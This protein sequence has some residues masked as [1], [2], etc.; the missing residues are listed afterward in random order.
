MKR[1][2]IVVLAITVIAAAALFAMNLY[3][4]RDPGQASR[5]EE[6]AVPLERPGL[7]NLHRVTEDFYRGA[8]P[9]AE[10]MKE[11]EAMGVKTVVNL[12]SF[13]SDRD[14]LEG[15]TLGHEHI[16][17]KTWH[18]EGEDVVRFLRV[19][20]DPERAPVFVHCQRGADRTGMMSAIYR[21]GVC[22]WTKEA[23]KEEMLNGGFGFA[24]TW[25]N[26]VAFFEEF[27]IEGAMTKVRAER[28]AEAEKEG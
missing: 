11:L 17:M 8:Q 16:S 20:T 12:R 26:M 5:R 24:Q 19:V 6:W 25:Q 14:E 13:H 3:T 27:D 10:G 21:V 18:P 2:I 22:G 23:A 4:S 15:T 7:Q 9:T 1:G 28:E